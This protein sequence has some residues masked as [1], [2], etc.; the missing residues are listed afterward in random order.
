MLFQGPLGSRKLTYDTY[1]KIRFRNERAFWLADNLP[2][3]A[4]FFHPGY[5]YQEP[6]RIFEFT[7]TFVQR[8][9][10]KLEP[11][12]HHPRFILTEA[13]VGYWM[14]APDE[15][16]TVASQPAKGAMSHR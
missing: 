14:P 2:F 8:I 12:R 4:E 5:I 13:G 1:R 15:S 11:D 9:R 10:R 7:R 6:V 3:R 16:T